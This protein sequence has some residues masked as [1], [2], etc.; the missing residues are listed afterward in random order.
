[1]VMEMSWNVRIW[2]KLMEFGDQSWTFA[3]FVP[4]FKQSAFVV[5]IK[6]LMTG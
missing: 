6:K 1:M 2:Q 5:D 4:E 3:N